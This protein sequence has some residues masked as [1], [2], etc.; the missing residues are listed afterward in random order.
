MLWLALLGWLAQLCMPVAHAAAMAERGL[1][2]ATWCG[3][4]SAAL[5]AKLAE[6]PGE[7][8]E[9]LKD[10]ISHGEHASEACADLCITP[11]GGALPVLAAT[12]ALRAAGIE[13]PVEP[14]AADALLTPRPNAFPARGPPKH[15]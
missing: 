1:G 5:E 8:R 13:K 4:G 9:I 10:S 2:L 12:V 11:P 14:T 7:I 15:T 6:L 3:Q